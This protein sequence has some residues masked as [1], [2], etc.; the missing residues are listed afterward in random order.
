MRVMSISRKCSILC[1]QV[2]RIA[3]EMENDFQTCYKSYGMHLTEPIREND[4]EKERKKK[5][6][7]ENVGKRA[8]RL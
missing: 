4:I 1:F 5:R 3:A 2:A 6:D 8:K 7:R